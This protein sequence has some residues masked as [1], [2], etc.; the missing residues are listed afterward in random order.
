V[1][2]GEGSEKVP[3]AFDAEPGQVQQRFGAEPGQFNRVREKVPGSLGA[4]PSQVQRVPEKVAERR[5]RRRFW[6]SLVHGQVRFNSFN[7]V[8]SAC[9]AARFRQICKN[10]KLRL[11]GIPPKLILRTC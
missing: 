11:L 5:S 3:G 6:E 7:R 10:K 9:F 2:S 1:R 4:K 8:S